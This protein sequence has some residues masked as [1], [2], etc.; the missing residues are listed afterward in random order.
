MFDQNSKTRSE[1]RQNNLKKN[2][3]RDLSLS[4]FKRLYKEVAMKT[5]ILEQ[6]N[7]HTYIKDTDQNLE[8]KPYMHDRVRF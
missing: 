5:V 6:A 8:I 2:K 3:V 1:N 4:D 7:R